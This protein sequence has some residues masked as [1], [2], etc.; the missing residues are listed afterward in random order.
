M[1]SIKRLDP[2]DIRA[3]VEWIRQTS[4]YRILV[5]RRTAGRR[6]WTLDA[7]SVT[8]PD[9]V[10]EHD[11]VAGGAVIVGYYTKHAEPAS[12]MADIATAMGEL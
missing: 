1:A 9:P 11:A 12:V 10:L 4:R 3:V 7:Y 5:L 2:L 8:R 6:N